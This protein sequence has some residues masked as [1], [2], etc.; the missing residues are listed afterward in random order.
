MSVECDE[1]SGKI[2]IEVSGNS[3]LSVYS[4]KVPTDSLW[5]AGLIKKA[6]VEI[7]GIV[8]WLHFEVGWYTEQFK[9]LAICKGISQW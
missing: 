3:G 9:L 4:P 2:I 7:N 5:A 1:I 8:G 6:E